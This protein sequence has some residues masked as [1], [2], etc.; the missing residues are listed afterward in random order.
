MSFQLSPGVNVTEIDLTAVIPSVATTDA[1]IG[2]VFRWGP[3]EKAILV[4]NE[5]QLVARFGRPTNL[6]AETFFTAASFL[7]YSDSLYVSRAVRTSGNSA[8][9]SADL[10]EGNTTITVS[11]AAG[12]LEGF[13]VFGP[14]I[15]SGTVVTS[16]DGNELVLSEDPEISDTGVSLQIFEADL[17]FNAVANSSS[18]VDLTTTIVKNEEHYDLVSSNFDTDAE[19]V[20]KYP[21]ELGNSL[22]V[23]VCP[24][25]AAFE[26]GIV[27]S[28]VIDDLNVANT[29]DQIEIS[30]VVGSNTAI[31]RVTPNDPSET[32]DATDSVAVANAVKNK[33]TIGDL[34]FAGNSQIGSTQLLQ[35][36]E[37]SNIITVA[38][39]DDDTVQILVS[40]EDRYS[41]S[42]NYSSTTIDRRWEFSRVTQLAPGQSTHQLIQGNTAA[43]DELHVVVSDEDGRISGV[44]GTILEVYQNLSRAT[45]SKTLDGAS[46]YYEEVIN[47]SSKFI[48][49]ANDF[50]G[51]A[52]SVVSSLLASSAL[53]T[54]Y[55]QSFVGGR[56]S[57]NEETI[58][59]GDL[60]NAYNLF[61]SNET[62]DISLILAGKARGGSHGEQVANYLVDNIAEKR[63]DCIVLISP[64]R[65]DVINNTFDI[66][67][68]VIQFRNAV[69]ST[70]YAVMDSGYKYMYD[71]YN[72]IYRYIPLNGDIGGL[73]A[74]TDD[75]R[76]AWF[77]PAGFNRGQIRNIV[78][79]AWNPK[80]AERDLLYKNG[81]NS[82]VNFPGQGIILFGDKTLLSKPS[83]FDRINV[84]RLFIVLEKAI[85]RASQST[86]FEFNDEFTRSS[87]VNLV[88]PFLRGVQG[89]RGITDFAVIC[90][91]TNNTGEVIDR[92]EFIG[93][94]Y[95][96][97]ARAIN[98]IQLNFVA[99]RTGVEFSEII[100]QF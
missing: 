89:R 33:L 83:A 99:V 86:L 78:K 67:A 24:S 98:F 35:I 51:N 16:I 5:D 17:A 38:Q 90:D 9:Y 43:Q 92:N 47:E 82:V 81:I 73:C 20:A 68:A 13:A 58:S 14:G 100:G 56:D 23:S 71:K 61:E 77:S 37:I 25:A 75:E 44:P 6:N 26:S 53:T 10:N 62:V 64:D 36:T 15:K 69:R 95:I 4:T 45:D 30:F 2:G 18:V 29:V 70:S 7:A 94:I 42:G 52:P 76:D 80:Q 46:N 27:G 87:F 28:E 60:I 48:W 19:F 88:T 39:S 31:I 79:L 96:K 55:T 59:V 50:D 11:N 22:K 8:V 91:E 49:F 54:P 32:Q 21:G 97:P 3:V 93:D 74:R 65:G 12:V 34:L 84:R 63:K 41:L 85:A 40:L 57:K 1:A 72:D 66:E